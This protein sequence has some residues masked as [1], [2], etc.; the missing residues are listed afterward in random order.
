MMNNLTEILIPLVNTIFDH[1]SMFLSSL[2]DAAVLSAAGSGVTLVFAV[3]ALAYIPEDVLAT[4]R[5]WHGS[6]DEQ[7]GNIDNLVNLIK[8]NQPA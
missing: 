2:S 5:R 3:G 7:F 8:A 4:V 1:T 6:I